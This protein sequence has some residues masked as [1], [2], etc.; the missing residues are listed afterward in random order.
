MTDLRAVAW[1]AYQHRGACQRYPELAGALEHVAA[2]RPR[3][4]LEIG[5]DS[6]GTLFCWRQLGIETFA[7]TLPVPGPQYVKT[8]GAE[9]LWGDSHDSASYEWIWARTLG[10]HSPRLL[11][12]LFIDG[13]HSYEGARADFEDYEGLVR[14]GGIVLIHDV[15]HADLLPGVVKLWGELQQEFPGQCVTLPGDETEPAGFG[16]LTIRR[17]TD[18]HG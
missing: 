8:H 14:D 12:V 15:L 3:L 9:L 2:L 6:G 7:I 4:L 16:V 18:G 13:D 1:E 5:V 11:D 17:G 10:R